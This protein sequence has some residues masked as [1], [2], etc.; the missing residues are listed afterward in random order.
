MATLAYKRPIAKHRAL[1]CGDF[2]KH[3]AR[4]SI[5]RYA[6]R[7]K[8]RMTYPGRRFRL[9]WL[10]IWTWSPQGVG[11]RR[12]AV[13]EVR[14]LAAWADG[15]SLPG[16]RRTRRR[17]CRSWHATAPSRSTSRLGGAAAEH[18]ESRPAEHHHPHHNQSHHPT[19]HAHT[20]CRSPVAESI[21]PR[22][23]TPSCR[24]FEPPAPRSVRSMSCDG[25]PKRR[26]VLTAPCATRRAA[27]TC[28]P[29]R[30]GGA[31]WARH[32]ACASAFPDST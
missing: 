2:G 11:R 21:S 25:R 4:V 16:V 14:F 12:A 23:G 29:R 9:R 26:I 7:P 3:P 24:F 1:I 32:R 31:R 8:W 6:E 20:H 10:M 28:G 13:S 18:S 15:I 27:P 5:S 19:H 22:R 17:A 30:R